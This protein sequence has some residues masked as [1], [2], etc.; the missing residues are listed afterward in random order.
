AGRGRTRGSPGPARGGVRRIPPA[1]GARRG[2]RGRGTT[3]PRA[4]T[5]P[6][7]ILRSRLDL[8]KASGQA[9]DD[10]LELLDRPYVA[11]AGRRLLDVEDLGGL[12]VAE[13]LEMTQGEDLAVERVHGGQGFLEQALAFGADGGH[14]GLGVVAE[15]LGGQGGGAG[16]GHGGVQG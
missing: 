4:R 8:P 7:R 6:V 13:L 10:L 5:G 1:R 2:G 14:A 15:Q 16:L 3:R 11:F 9:L 12:G